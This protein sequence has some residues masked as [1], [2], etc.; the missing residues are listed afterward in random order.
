MNIIL[1]YFMTYMI[2]LL[3]LFIYFLFIYLFIIV[4][5]YSAKE[6]KNMTNKLQYNDNDTRNLGT[7]VGTL[8]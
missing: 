6:S 7:F 5:I 1:L 2:V 8:V 4:V 3:S